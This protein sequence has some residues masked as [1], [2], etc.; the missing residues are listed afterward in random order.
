LTDLTRRRFLGMTTAAV[1]GVVAAPALAACAGSPAPSHVTIAV[2]TL[3]NL[4]VAPYFVARDR[5]LFAAR[6][7]ETG[8][9]P[10]RSSTSSLQQLVGGHASIA[11]MNALLFL[12]AVA[13]QGA[14]L[15]AVGIDYQ[16]SVFQVTSLATRPVHS[17]AELTGKTIGLPSFGGGAEEAFDALLE[18]NHI[19]KGAVKR[20][21]TGT[22]PAAVALLQDRRVDA[23]LTLFE[24]EVAIRHAGTD[25]TTFNLTGPNPTFGELFVVTK[26]TRDKRAVKVERF[27]AALASGYARL[28]DPTTRSQTLQELS[29]SDI[30]VLNDQAAAR[31]AMELIVRA[32]D[33]AGPENR[34]R[35]VADA[36][37]RNARSLVDAGVLKQVPGRAAYTNELLPGGRG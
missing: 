17:F 5:G 30:D 14:P 7:L 34:L 22:A 21:V 6:G 23:M 28:A 33:A 35:I 24:Q 2:A 37:D 31:D 4:N 26:A 16:Q 29:P 18:I 32:W 3:P 20:V 9:A 10:S 25:L 12:R 11:R 27:L 13:D 15:V 36:W 1:G 19:D 8:I